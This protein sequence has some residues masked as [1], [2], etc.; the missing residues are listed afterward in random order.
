MDHVIFAESLDVDYSSTL[1][2]C[3]IVGTDLLMGAG[4]NNGGALVAQFRSAPAN[5]DGASYRFVNISVDGTE[6]AN[7]PEARRRQIHTTVLARFSPSTVAPRPAYN[8]DVPRPVLPEFRAAQ[9]DNLR[10]GATNRGDLFGDHRLNSL[11]L[12]PGYYTHNSAINDQSHGLHITLRSGVY[13]FEEFKAP[14]A[15]SVTVEYGTIIYA[16]RVTWDSGSRVITPLRTTPIS[17]GNQPNANEQIPLIIIANTGT[18]VIHNNSTIEAAVIVPHGRLEVNDGSTLRGQLLAQEIRLISLKNGNAMTFIPYRI[19]DVGD[20]DITPGNFT[21]EKQQCG[22]NFPAEITVTLPAELNNRVGSV[23]LPYTIRQFTSAEATAAAAA[24]PNLSAEQRERVTYANIGASGTDVIVNPVSGMSGNLGFAVETRSQSISFTIVND[25][26]WDPN[27]RLFEISFGNPIFSAQADRDGFA[28]ESPGAFTMKI[29][30]QGT[31]F[32]APTAPTITQTLL[33]RS[34]APVVRHG[35]I[36]RPAVVLGESGTRWNGWSNQLAGTLDSRADEGRPTTTRID[37]EILGVVNPANPTAP[38]VEFNGVNR[39][40][41]NITTDRIYTT[42][43]FAADFENVAHQTIT[44]RVRATAVRSLASHLVDCR[45][46]TDGNVV[47]NVHPW[48]D[49]A[50]GTVTIPSNLSVNI[51][52]S[53]DIPLTIPTD[54]DMPADANL[55]IVRFA[56]AQGASGWNVNNASG[57]SSLNLPNGNVSFNSN[58]NTIRLENAASDITFF[59]LV[60]DTAAYNYVVQGT[61]T[62]RNTDHFDQW[63]RVDVNV[64]N[65]PNPT[66]NL[67]PATICRNQ[68]A[69]FNISSLGAPFNAGHTFVNV[70]VDGGAAN[71]TIS[72]TI[73]A[74]GVTSFTFTPSASGAT[75]VTIR[76]QVRNTDNT[77]TSTVRT[78]T[79]TVNSMVNQT[80]RASNETIDMQIGET[81]N[82]IDFTSRWVNDIGQPI[83]N[84]RAIIVTN[85][86]SPSVTVTRAADNRRFNVSVLPT[87]TLSEGATQ[88]FVFRIEYVTNPTGGCLEGA[89]RSIDHTV[90]INIDGSAVRP[91]PQPDTIIVNRDAL[92]NPTATTLWNSETN[93]LTNDLGSSTGNHRADG[94]VVPSPNPFNTSRGRVTLNANGTFSYTHTAT[95]TQLTPQAEDRFTYHSLIT[96]QNNAQSVEPAEVAIIVNYFNLH[97]PSLREKYGILGVG[98]RS[99]FPVINAYDTDADEGTHLKLNRGFS[100]T[101][102]KD[103]TPLTL[104]SNPGNIDIGV[105]TDRQIFVQYHGTTAGTIVINFEVNDSVDYTHFYRGRN[106]SNTAD[107][108]RTRPYNEFGSYPNTLTLTISA[109]PVPTNDEMCVNETFTLNINDLGSNLGATEVFGAV[110]SITPNLLSYVVNEGTIVFT[111][112]STQVTTPLPNTVDIRYTTVTRV[113]SISTQRTLNLTINPVKDQ[114]PVASDTTISM[115][116]GGNPITLDLTDNWTNPNAL[117]DESDLIVTDIDR[118]G[119]S[120]NVRVELLPDNRRFRITVLP[121][122]SLSENTPQ[123]FRYRIVDNA[124]Y[125]CPYDEILSAWRIVRINIETGDD[126]RPR[127]V[128]DTIIVSR[129]YNRDASG[130]IV[131][132]TLWNGSLSVLYNDLLSVHGDFPADRVAVAV[133]VQRGELD[134]RPDGTFT[135]KHTATLQPAVQNEDGFSYN[136]FITVQGNIES[137]NPAEVLIFVNWYNEHEPELAEKTGAL[138]A[139]ELAT[140]RVI[141]NRDTDLDLNTVIRLDRDTMLVATLGTA[142]GT[143]VLP[144]LIE[145]GFAPNDSS[146]TV[147]YLGDITEETVIVVHFNVNDHVNFIHFYN[148]NGIFADSVYAEFGSYR[149]TLTL[150]ISP[151]P[152]AVDFRMEVIELQSTDTLILGSD[153]F[154]NIAAGLG[155]RPED[156]GRTWTIALCE[157]NVAQNGTIVFSSI[158]TRVDYTHRNAVYPEGFSDEFDYILTVIL[159]DGSTIETT[160]TITVAVSRREAWAFENLSFYEAIGGRA[161]VVDRVIIPFDRAIDPQTEFLVHFH[162]RELG[163][164]SRNLRA[165]TEAELEQNTAIEQIVELELLGAL[166]NTTAGTGDMTVYIEHPR[167]I[168]GAENITIRPRDRAA[169]VIVNA[170]Y[171]ES[172]YGANDTLILTMSEPSLITASGNLP[173]RFATTAD[174]LY[175]LTF[176]QRLV[177]PENPLL[178]TMILAPNNTASISAGDSVFINWEADIIVSDH[179]RNEQT[180]ER[181]I[182]VPI[183]RRSVTQIISATYFND[184]NVGGAHDGFINRISFDFGMRVSGALALEIVRSLEL[185]A[186]RAFIISDT[187]AAITPTDIGFDLAV[188]ETRRTRTVRYNESNFVVAAPETSV[189]T[190][191]DII[192]VR[193]L[194]HGT[195]TIEASYVIATDGVAPVV[196]YATYEFTP[197]DTTLRVVFSEPVRPRGNAVVSPYRFWS[198]TLR[199]NYPNQGMNFTATPPQGANSI[200]TY[201]VASTTIPFP[202]SG[203]SLWI[204]QGEHIFDTEGNEAELTVRAPLILTNQYADSLD[205]WVVPQPLRLVNVKNRTE[206]AVLDEGLARYYQIPIGTQGVALIVEAM[207]PVHPNHYNNRGTMRIIDN[208]GNVVRENVEM[209]FVVIQDGDRAGN[210]VGVAV[211]DG[212]NESGRFVGAASYLALIDVSVQFYDRPSPVRRDFRRQISVSSAGTGDG[213]SQR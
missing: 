69:T 64:N 203:D 117:S 196:L 175:T 141:D 24:D 53:L 201:E 48:N 115:E 23:T 123:T 65:P 17:C 134:L 173:F 35:V 147:R 18:T 80:P 205:L 194:E 135:Y 22:T 36:E 9:F 165:P 212:K 46:V 166:P 124:D 25:G 186:S 156:R 183:E 7:P 184:P 146:I 155:L 15:G 95:T 137:A 127:P 158:S 81:R 187:V 31:E 111:R 195:N 58:N 107:S 97:S 202:V 191:T 11:V 125:D 119:L 21:F 105:E 113:G 91:I 190:N 182:R 49:I 68:T 87:Y 172:F 100:F 60:R 114:I 52:G 170:V 55:Q 56:A 143:P 189:D 153:R 142:N 2:E 193:R 154:E 199:T 207:G 14:G 20:I 157:T 1:P 149:N 130:D 77:L 181:N 177:H 32:T 26:R 84:I 74:T 94:V 70:S 169:P 174:E 75:P 42:S 131:V 47:I 4:F 98:Q 10:V 79:V 168:P 211:W 40:W 204:M 188:A 161:N 121:A 43:N 90:T 198:S 99:V 88:R 200:W 179:D 19:V 176:L 144:S 104:G 209:K 12:D 118:D 159:P 133:D 162:S 128:P 150:T 167:T 71:G 210:V 116:I 178:Y 67:S 126:N 93:L 96:G 85:P 41:F 185:P 54:G 82:N 44:L 72:P 148:D 151:N 13:F 39:N 112:N 29:V 62:V 86:V 110:Q 101:A 59:V 108:I 16:R 8:S 50:L 160:G 30:M 73:P 122:F 61:Q 89:I 51:G 140:F 103:G 6:Q 66:T 192:A 37:Y 145:L 5:P 163:I 109:N 208:I 38:L 197:S 45:N 129:R 152:S 27:I 78:V 213:N 28:M 92:T 3:G 180:N 33:T 63:V 34:G 139:G 57:T 132:D 138:Q 120:S 76:Y 164:R 106:L 206:P 136:S 102:T 83:S 171:I